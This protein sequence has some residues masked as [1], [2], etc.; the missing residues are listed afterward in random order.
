MFARVTEHD[1]HGVKFRSTDRSRL[2]VSAA[3]SCATRRDSTQSSREPSF[4]VMTFEPH[5]P[6]GSRSVARGVRGIECVGSCG[7]ALSPDLFGIG[8]FHGIIAQPLRNRSGS[9]NELLLVT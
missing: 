7:D 5:V 4:R 1:N 3:T 6:P 2:W 9:V 8:T